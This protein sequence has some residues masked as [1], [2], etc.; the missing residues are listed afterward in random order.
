MPP[1]IIFILSISLFMAV[2]WLISTYN[3]F[4]KY[5]NRIEEAWSGI[6]VALKRRFNL[7][8]NLIRSVE[9]YSKHEADIFKTKSDYLAGL[10]NIADRSQEES[11]ISKSLR[12]L[13]ALAQAYPELKASANFID[14]QNSLNETEEDIQKARNRYN[15][16]VGRFNTLVESFPAVFI[17]RRCGFEK[18]TYFTLDLATQREL[19]E[20]E[21]SASG[22]SKK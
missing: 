15:S 22:V 6:D 8:P 14:L 2:A 3:R 12:G 16:F 5:K 13:L 19:P 17:A 21:F 20:V 10:T 9:G 18:R 7:I 4:I 1:I 11:R